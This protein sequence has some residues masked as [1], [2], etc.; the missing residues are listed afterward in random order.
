MSTLVA[1]GTIVTAVS[2]YEADVLVDGGQIVQIGRGLDVPDAERIDAGGKFVLPRRA[3]RA[4]PSRHAVGGQVRD[5]RRLARRL[6][7]GGLRR[8][9][10]DR[11]L[12]APGEGQTL[13]QAIDGWHA[14]AEGKA[15]STTG[16]TR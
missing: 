7:R 6:D 15:S 1:G 10:H 11:R 16:S 5:R 3:R 2:T 13:R 8:D 12:R 9:D 14:K 4:H